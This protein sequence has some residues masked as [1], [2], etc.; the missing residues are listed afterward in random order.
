MQTADPGNK[1]WKLFRSICLKEFPRRTSCPL[2]CTQFERKRAPECI[3]VGAA[4]QDAEGES[5][6][7]MRL[8]CPRRAQ[9]IKKPRTVVVCE[10]FEKAFNV[11]SPQVLEEILP[12]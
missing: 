7:A 8:R 3:L 6:N 9:L 12:S 11:A 2:C 5:H 1:G 10:T 4:S